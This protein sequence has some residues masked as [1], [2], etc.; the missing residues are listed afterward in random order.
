MMQVSYFLLQA[1]LLNDELSALKTT[2]FLH[3]FGRFFFYN[4][5]NNPNF[6]NKSDKIK[7]LRIQMA[8]SLSM[9]SL[10]KRTSETDVFTQRH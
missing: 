6:N 5:S 7:I 10:H 3:S 4:Y 9:T 1:Q 8:V 2:V